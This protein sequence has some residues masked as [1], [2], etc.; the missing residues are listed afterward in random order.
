M[1]LTQN[2]VSELADLD[3]LQGFSK[4]THVSFMDNPVAN[5]EVCFSHRNL[6]YFLTNILQ[7]YR[8]YVLWR[9]PHIRFL[10][11]QKVKDAE[12]NKA[13]DLF[14]TFESPTDL[15]TS[16]MALRSGNLAGASNVQ[17]IN[18]VGKA[19]KLK[20][21][22]NEKKRFEALVKKA[23]TLSEVQRLEKAFA[24]G[25]LPAG[26]GDEDGMDTT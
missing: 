5:K 15:A 22:E 7:H 8:Y 26:V 1:V 20:I 25:R 2:N 23:K 19:S 9:C 10:D 6:C 17:A 12:R 14:G 3:A 13:V 11:Y 24:E 4:L 21:T 16:I 18:G